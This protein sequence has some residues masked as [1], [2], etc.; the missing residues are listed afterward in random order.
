MLCPLELTYEP[1]TQDTVINQIIKCALS[2]YNVRYFKSSTISPRPCIIN[3]NVDT[4]TF[5]KNTVHLETTC[6]KVHYSDTSVSI[7][8]KVQVYIR[9]LQFYMS[10]YVSTTV[11]TQNQFS[12]DVTDMNKLHIH[13]QEY[14]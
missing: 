7:I 4:Q 2:N 10:S 5:C 9:C 12:A 11:I 13:E 1:N 3:T 14:Q 6:C 8:A